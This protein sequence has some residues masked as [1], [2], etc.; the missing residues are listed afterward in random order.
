MKNNIKYKLNPYWMTGLTDAEGCFYV[1]IAKSKNH[2]VGWWTQV[3]FQLGLHIRYKDL[4]L[5]IKSFLMKQEVFIQWIRIKR[6]F[7]KYVI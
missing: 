3:C 4:L 6:C 5:Q 7:I 2:K 1:K